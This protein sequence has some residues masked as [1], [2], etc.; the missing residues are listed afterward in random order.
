MLTAVVVFLRSIGLLCRG[1]RA[2]ALENLALRQQ[3]AA[4]TR[5]AKTPASS[6]TGSTLLD[7]AQELVARLAQRLDDRAARHGRAL[8]PR[9]APT[10]MD[11]TLTTETS[12]APAARMPRFGRSSAKWPSANPLW[13]APRIHGELRKLGI[14]VSE[15]TGSRFVRRRARPVRHR[16]G[17]PSSTNHV[18]ALVSMDFFTVPTLTG[19]VLFVLVLLAHDR[20]RVVHV[21]VT[22]HPTAEWTAQQIVAAFPEDAAPKWLC[23][24]NIPTVCESPRR[25]AIADQTNRSRIPMMLAPIAI[26]DPQ[27]S[28]A[29][30]LRGPVREPRIHLQRARRESTA[31]IQSSAGPGWR[32]FA[33]FCGREGD[34]E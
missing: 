25:R 6:A 24:A 31:R 7:A 23:F 4:L 22:E 34:P 18:S 14:E 30:E 27:R 26:G 1:H 9:M 28:H 29:V 11:G 12:G 13:G 2:V 32:S 15:R 5:T 16:R 20:R 10:S 21:T 19:R 33:C 17:E 3:L 8:A